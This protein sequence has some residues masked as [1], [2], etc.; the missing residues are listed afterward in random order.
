[1]IYIYNT[2][3]I[4]NAIYHI[5][6]TTAYLPIYTSTS[7]VRQSKWTVSRASPFVEAEKCEKTELLCQGGR[8][9]RL[10]VRLAFENGSH[11]NPEFHE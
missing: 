9:G 10:E 6:L 5:Y 8:G 2:I 3:Y 7:S 1:M 4:Y 11:E